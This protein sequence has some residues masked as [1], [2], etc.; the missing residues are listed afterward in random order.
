MLN[1]FIKIKQKKDIDV[2][3]RKAQHSTSGSFYYY[4]FF[5]SF[6]F[7]IYQS[8]EC[9]KGKLTIQ[10]VT[11]RQ[12]RCVSVFKNKIEKIQQQQKKKLNKKKPSRCRTLNVIQ[13][14]EANVL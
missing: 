11:V 1:I 3:I 13:R 8:S 4:I 14:K 6:K 9:F 12:V 7:L 10:L 2:S 5:L